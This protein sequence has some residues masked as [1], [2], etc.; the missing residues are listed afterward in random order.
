MSAYSR[1]NERARAEGFSSYGQQRRAGELGYNT[2]GEYQRAKLAARSDREPMPR[3][4]GMSGTRTL[5]GGA[6]VGRMGKAFGIYADD[7]SQLAGVRG[8]LGRY[9]DSRR[10]SVWIGG[11]QVGGSRGFTMGYL[12]DWIDD[13]Y[14]GD[15]DAWLDDVGDS[16][17]DAA[18]GGVSVTIS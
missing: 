13:E 6:E 12:R 18:P 17:M 2:A 8:E 9:S 7:R 5:R 10:V 1:R 15:F 16:Y 4:P 14:D 3:A 11:A